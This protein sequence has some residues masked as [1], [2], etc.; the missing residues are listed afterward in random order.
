MKCFSV[1]IE[2]GCSFCPFVYWY[3]ILHGVLKKVKPTLHLWYIIPLRYCWIWFANTSLGILYVHKGCWF[4]A[5]FS[6]NVFI[7]IW[8]KGNKHLYRISYFLYFRKNLCMI[9]SILKYLIEFTSESIWP[10]FFFVV[11]FN[12]LWLN[13]HPKEYVEVLIPKNSECVHIRKQGHFRCH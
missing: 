5:F 6:C 8:Y 7:W 13:C 10:G 1:S 2:M 9:V 3:S 12:L 11:L 4:A